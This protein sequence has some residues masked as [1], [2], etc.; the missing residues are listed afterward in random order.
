MIIAAV[1]DEDDYNAAMKSKV[2]CIFMMFGDIVS[3][4]EMTVQA[5]QRDILI[6][7][8][9]ELI[10]GIAN[11]EY[12]VLYLKNHV[13]PFGIIST[14]KKLIQKAHELGMKT[15]LHFF[16]IDSKA[17]SK[18]IN[19][20]ME[21]QPD[22]IEIMPGV[23]PKVIETLKE[24][25]GLPIIAGGLIESREEYRSAMSAGAYAVTTSARKFWN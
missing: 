2:K 13:D 15:A 22:Y 23:I 7:I 6:F 4:R 3:I 5:Q 10:K 1:R 19:M 12:G 14:K 20:S 24:Q 11:D 21:C 9:I 17:L 8:H 18:A 16:V 25:T